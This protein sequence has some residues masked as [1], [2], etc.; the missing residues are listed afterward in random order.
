MWGTC[1]LR[2]LRCLACRVGNARLNVTVHGRPAGIG[3]VSDL[4]MKKGA[5]MQGSQ[6][7]MND[8]ITL[9]QTS[10]RDLVVR[11]GLSTPPW[12]PSNPHLDQFRRPHVSCGCSRRQAQRSSTLH[13]S[14]QGSRLWTTQPTS[15]ATPV[16]CPSH[17][18]S[19]T[20][21][22]VLSACRQM[23]CR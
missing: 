15:R 7:V 9:A 13:P 1:A 16:C 12:K 19:S 22:L 23:E 6:S 21:T 20:S 10:L 14:Q 11:P 17:P 8:L 5:S 2:L 3:V 4:A 18:R